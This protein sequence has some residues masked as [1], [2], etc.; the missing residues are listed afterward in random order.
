MPTPTDPTLYEKIKQNIITKNKPNFNLEQ[1]VL[2]M[3]LNI[4]RKARETNQK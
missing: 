3:V 4:R 2:E 1:A